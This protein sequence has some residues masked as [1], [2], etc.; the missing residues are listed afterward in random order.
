MTLEQ[1]QYFIAAAE[2]GS[3]SKAADQMYISHSTISRAVASLE[4]ELGVELFRRGRSLACTP[5]GRV[6]LENGKALI[7][8]S[9]ALK[10]SVA[11]YQKSLRLRIMTVRAYMPRVYE[12]IRAFREAY[13]DVEIGMEEADQQT[14]AGR[15][16][17]GEADVTF[18]FSYSWPQD[19]NLEYM[20]VEN[21]RFCAVLS[22]QHPLASKSTLDP[23]EFEKWEILGENPFVGG[24]GPREETDIQSI[25][26]QIKAG[27][28]ITIVPEH[29]AQEFG[30]GCRIVPISE[31]NK[32]YQIWM[33]WRK[34]NRSEAL[35]LFRVFFEAS[36]NAETQS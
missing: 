33:G 35:R 3:Y 4:K 16:R 14:T 30:H 29:A 11:G 20:T 28:G 12:T 32:E 36:V 25:I 24:S 26:L 31:G 5:A 2:A 10:D 18:S 22:R 27:N 1:V 8:Q 19:E 17:S 15:L 34:K 13:P 21:G 9:V 6:F 23:A 7:R